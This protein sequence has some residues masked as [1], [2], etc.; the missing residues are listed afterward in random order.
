[1]S[2]KNPSLCRLA[3]QSTHLLRFHFSLSLHPPAT[4]K[5]L[6]PSRTRALESLLFYDVSCS[7][8]P[9]PYLRT[10]YR[11]KEESKAKQIDSG[12]LEQYHQRTGNQVTNDK[13]E[14]KPNGCS[15][16]ILHSLYPGGVFFPC[17]L[18]F[19]LPVAPPSRINVPRESA[20]KREMLP[21]SGMPLLRLGRI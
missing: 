9:L 7:F 6:G 4:L 14:G 17:A 8:I 1:M 13:P 19:Y 11:A 3:Y 21:R 5:C 20:Q 15:G 2:T 10:G 18:F 12:P 16:L